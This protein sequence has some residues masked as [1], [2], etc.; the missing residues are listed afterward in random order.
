[1][2]YKCQCGKIIGVDFTPKPK[3]ENEVSHDIV[4]ISC[5]NREMETRQRKER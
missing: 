4:C 1:M 5:W 3:N 2:I